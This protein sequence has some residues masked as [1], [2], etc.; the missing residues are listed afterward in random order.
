MGN[1]GGN[2][3]V[4]ASSIKYSTKEDSLH[5]LMS[6][7]YT[8][9]NTFEAVRLLLN[10][11]VGRNS[12]RKYLKSEYAAE[13]L[14][15]YEEVEL[16]KSAEAGNIAV[17]S[18]SLCENYLKPGSSN[19]VNISDA[20]KSKLLSLLINNENLFAE[21]ANIVA[22]LVLSQSEVM[23]ILAMNGFPRFVTSPTFK[24]WVTEELQVAEKVSPV[25][26]ATAPNTFA[27]SALSSME[28]A[29][30]E[31][32]CKG[33]IWLKQ[34]VALA[35]LLP[36]A[37]SIA[38]ANPSRRGLP[39]IYVNPEFTVLTGYSREECI[40]KNCKFLQQPAKSERDSI[41]Q[42]VKAVHTKSPARIDITNFKKDGTYFR[43]LVCMK[44]LLNQTGEVGYFIAIHLDITSEGLSQK[45]SKFADSLLSTLPDKF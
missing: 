34:L 25:T 9:S 37:V 44:A 23:A 13:G 4:A 2:A 16:F 30:F 29:E 40:G 15:Y 31:M 11:S 45:I 8:N 10:D 12:F 5:E 14:L 26:I 24:T 32:I 18:R 21:K 35:E 1:C 19:E 43:N 42:F 3:K 20:M 41:N 39:L 28:A 38:T 22:E 6:S 17:V 33:A 36:V 7:I 27:V